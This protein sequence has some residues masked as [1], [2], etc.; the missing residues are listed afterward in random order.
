MT[1][2][3]A[4]VHPLKYFLNFDLLI[5]AFAFVLFQS[6]VGFILS[7][8]I[9]SISPITACSGAEEYTTIF[10]T[11][12][13]GIRFRYSYRFCPPNILCA[14]SGLID[15]KIVAMPHCLSKC[16]FVFDLARIVSKSASEI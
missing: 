10:D 13:W 4:I 14:Y 11:S 1:K 12:F 16:I 15:Y 7:V 3:Y 9:T 2:A 5:P 8:L 6:G